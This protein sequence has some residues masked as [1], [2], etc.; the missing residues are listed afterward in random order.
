MPNLQL[1]EVSY[2]HS[3]KFKCYL[4]LDGPGKSS[5][6]VSPMSSTADNLSLSRW[7]EASLLTI[8]GRGWGGMPSHQLADIMFAMLWSLLNN[9]L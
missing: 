7:Q 1:T 5:G 9:F 8:S 3:S 2:V 4:I 6:P